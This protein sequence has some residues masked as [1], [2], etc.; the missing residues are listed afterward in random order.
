[1]KL[2]ELNRVLFD[3]ASRNH[4]YENTHVSISMKWEGTLEEYNSTCQEVSVVDIH[5]NRIDI[6]VGQGE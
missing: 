6:Y 5:D 3:L 4:D 1:M 2:Y